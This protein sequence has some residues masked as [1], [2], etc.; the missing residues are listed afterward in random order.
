VCGFSFEFSL[1][2][3]IHC[4]G[5]CI[6]DY[7]SLPKQGNQRLVRNQMKFANLAKAGQKLGRKNP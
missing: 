1:S 4:S 5:I 6:S 3:F 2:C 7:K